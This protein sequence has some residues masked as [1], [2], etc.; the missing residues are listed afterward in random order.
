MKSDLRIG[1]RVEVTFGSGVDSGAT[2]TIVDQRHLPIGDRGTPKIVG[3]YKPFDRLNEFVVRRDHP[4]P[5]G[6]YLTMYK[7]RLRKIEKE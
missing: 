5:W 3:H 6:P 7:N 1:D 4:S 2:G